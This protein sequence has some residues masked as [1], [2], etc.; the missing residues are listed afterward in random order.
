MRSADIQDRIR[1]HLISFVADENDDVEVV[2]S[3]TG[4]YEVFTIRRNGNEAYQYRGS[5]HPNVVCE[6]NPCHFCGMSFYED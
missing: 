6:G 3:W 4:G 2:Y 1:E 5:F